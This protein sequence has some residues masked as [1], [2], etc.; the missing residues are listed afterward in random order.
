MNFV[1]DQRP[2]EH[3]DDV[4]VVAYIVRLCR[5]APPFTKGAKILADARMAFAGIDEVRLKSCAA[6][7]ASKLIA[8]GSYT[9]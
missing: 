8:Q 2:P 9:R 3:L 1:L 6:T 4:E 5:S 7:A